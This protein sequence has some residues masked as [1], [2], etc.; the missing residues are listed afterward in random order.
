MMR[1]SMAQLSLDSG[2]DVAVGLVDGDEDVVGIV[3]AEGSQIGEQ[4]MQVGHGELDI[5]DFGGR[6]ESGFAHVEERVLH[7]PAVV[8]GEGPE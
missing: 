6:F 2:F 7:A 5:R 4:M 8:R 3:L 1:S